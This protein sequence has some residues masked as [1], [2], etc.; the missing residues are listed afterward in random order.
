MYVGGC[1]GIVWVVITIKMAL[2]KINKKLITFV[3]ICF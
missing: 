3:C 2:M 1:V